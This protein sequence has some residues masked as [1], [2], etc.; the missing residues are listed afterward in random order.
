MNGKNLINQK[1]IQEKIIF[2]TITKTGKEITF[3]YPTIDDAQILTEYINT[4]SAEKTFI[5]FQGEQKTLADEKKWIESFLN[6]KNTKVI[7]FAFINRQLVG[8]S[9]IDLKSGA[10]CNVGSFG[11]TVAK[12]FRGEGIGKTLMELTISE[13]I[14]N[15]KDLK[16]I[17]LEVF[18]SNIVAKNLYKKLGFIEFGCLPKSLKRKEDFDDAILMYKKV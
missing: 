18:G 10:K 13:S 12:E 14:K 5:I 4:I 7:V 11:I 9:D 2:Q 17:E 15:I 16:I 3:R 1:V 6:N 8:V